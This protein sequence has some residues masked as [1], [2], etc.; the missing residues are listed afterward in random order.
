MTKKV[1][2]V[3]IDTQYDCDV[4]GVFRKHSQVISDDFLTGLKEQRNASKEK[5]EGEY[6]SPLSRPS[7]SRAG[8][9]KASTSCRRTQCRRDREAAQA[10]EPRRLPHNREERLMASNKKYSKTVTN[11]KT[12]GRRPSAMARRD[13]P[14]AQGQSVAIATARVPPAR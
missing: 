13:T 6:A 2:P 9:A 5:R 12:G 3:G 1:D 10:R 14:S 8:C 11:P 4:G 7:W